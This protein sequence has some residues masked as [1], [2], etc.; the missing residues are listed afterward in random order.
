MGSFTISLVCFLLPLTMVSSF[1]TATNARS[2]DGT[3]T[4]SR[5][6]PCS[7]Y[8]LRKFDVDKDME[9]IRN[10]CRDV[11]G[12]ADYLPKTAPI[13]AGDPNSSF[14]VLADR[15][16]DRLAAVGNAR[17]FKPNM[18][19]LEAIR[20]CPDHRSRGLARHLTQSLIE[21]SLSEHGHAMYSCT[22]ESNLAMRKVF[23]RTGMKE[24]GQIYQCSFA[25][26]KKL[27]GWA[28]D[29]HGAATSIT[30]KSLLSSLGVTEELIGFHAKQMQL[31]QVSSEDELNNALAQIKAK[32][33]IG[34]LVGLY[35]LLPDEGVHKSL[36]AY[37]VWKLLS[38]TNPGD[39]ALIALVHEGKISSL[40][41]PWVCSISATSMVALEGALWK[42][43]SD[44]CLKAIPDH[45]AFTVAFDV[46]GET[47]DAQDM[48]AAVE[49]LPLTDDGCLLFGSA[50]I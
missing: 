44:Q 6:S 14:V 45:V 25:E 43:C 35:E 11:Y 37:R 31:V 34:H 46:C 1:S 17:R 49:A 5:T 42:A 13:L 29:D 33:G 7:S 26:L 18:S 36:D 28:A 21:T 38:R 32:G 2:S 47:V 41:S 48:P 8:H 15:S 30:P 9:A 12:G 50:D 20:T 19:W 40:K 10:I 4:A 23:D 39:F 3:D 16:T 22:V 27:P 24:L